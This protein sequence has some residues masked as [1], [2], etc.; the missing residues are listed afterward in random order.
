MLNNVDKYKYTQKNL[1]T[2]AVSNDYKCYNNSVNKQHFD[3]SH[4]VKW[5]PQV[6]T[7]LLLVLSQ[8][9]V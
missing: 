8:P 5:T 6:R 9:T 2:L 1:C 4:Q 3:I 7:D